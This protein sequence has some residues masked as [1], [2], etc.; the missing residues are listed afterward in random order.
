MNLF[1]EL[2]NDI[3]KKNVNA[4]IIIINIFVFLSISSFKIIIYLFD[5]NTIDDVNAYFA[6]PSNLKILTSRLWTLFTYMFSHDNLFFLLFNM[7]IF[8]PFSKIFTYYLPKS[9]LAAIY[10]LGGF[11]GAI[12]F[13]FSYNFFPK[14][15]LLKTSAIAMGSS[16]SVIA[17][18]LTTALLAKNEKLKIAFWEVKIIYIVLVI[19]ALDLFLIPN[20][21]AGGHLAHLGGACFGIIFSL[22]YK[23]KIDI[24][25]WFID[26]SIA[27]VSIFKKDKDSALKEEKQKRK[28]EQ[29]KDQEKTDKILEKIKKKGYSSL[30]E[31]EKKFLFKK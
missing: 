13:I 12:F 3:R 19:I 24:T 18:C 25:K 30:S 11:F 26:F 8:Y 6:I 17:V 16:A 20:G 15:G 4:I 23:K 14:F 5:I 9:R 31:N 21:N 29:E 7:L 10:I 27:F 1:K 2:Y 22:L 28:R